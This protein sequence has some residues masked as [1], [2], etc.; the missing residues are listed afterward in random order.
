MHTEIDRFSGI[1][2]LRWETTAGANPLIERTDSASQAPPSARRRRT[3]RPVAQASNLE[4]V[5]KALIEATVRGLLKE[6][7]EHPRRDLHVPHGFE[8]EDVTVE[9]WANIIAPEAL[10][11]WLI[12][13]TSN[14]QAR[15][16][17]R[18]AELSTQ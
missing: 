18:Q 9:E 17:L 4:A 12:R 2:H 13:A 5:T 1:D 3:A 7:H 16:R 15:P 14:I 6:I 11:E 10:S 8:L